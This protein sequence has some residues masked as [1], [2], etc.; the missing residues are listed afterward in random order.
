MAFLLKKFKSYLARKSNLYNKNLVEILCDKDKK[1][2]INY[3]ISAIDRAI[4]KASSLLAYNAVVIA[5]YAILAADNYNNIE[6]RIGTFI[7]MAACIVIF[8]IFHVE[9]TYTK[10]LKNHDDILQNMIKKLRFRAVLI[11]VALLFSF[12][13]TLY[14]GLLMILTP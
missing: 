3:T 2:A 11:D 12:V 8:P 1:L 10:N 5:I 6:W 4:N 7:A 13:S 9:F 14:V